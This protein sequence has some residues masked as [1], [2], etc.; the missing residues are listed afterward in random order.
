MKWCAIINPAANHAAEA[1]FRRVVDRL[2]H[3]LLADCVWTEYPGHA[4]LLARKTTGYDGCI[5]V[6]GDG[7]LA[8]VV[9]GLRLEEQVFGIIPRGTGNGLA[10]DLLLRDAEVAFDALTR[11]HFADLD[12]VHVAYRAGGEWQ[13]SYV[14]STSALGYVAG[15]TELGVGPLKS[16]GWLRYAAA[17]CVQLT[18]P[19]EFAA[20]LRIDDDGWED[21]TLTNLTVNNSRHAGPFAMFPDA[22]LDDGRM[23]VYGGRFSAPR[24]LAED[25][26]IFTRTYLFERARRWQVRR[27]D[28]VLA[29]PSTLM[30]DGELV[31]GVTEVRFRVARRRLHCCVPVGYRAAVNRVGAVPGRA[32]VAPPE[33]ASR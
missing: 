31:A 29:Q 18:R 16:W 26:G 24:Q 11:G 20:R 9:N 22:R 15:V 3:S 21:V 5:A 25:L 12:L 32:S 4:R 2:R 23:D 14:V 19:Q 1:E 28:V 13:E 10:R 33:K 17:A 30:L 8:A 6:G 7:T 27:L